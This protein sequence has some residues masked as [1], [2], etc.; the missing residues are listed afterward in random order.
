MEEVRLGL[1]LATETVA[2]FG[3]DYDEIAALNF[4]PQRASRKVLEAA[5]AGDKYWGK[6]DHYEVAARGIAET[7]R[8]LIHQFR[9]SEKILLPAIQVLRGSIDE[10]AARVE[11]LGRSTQ[12]ALGDHVAAL[13]AAGTVAEVM[14]YLHARIADWDVSVWHPG[15][16]EQAALERRLRVRTIGREP[17]PGDRALSADEALAGQRMLVVLGGP[18]SGKTWLARRYA[19]E[20]AHAA[21]LSLEDGADVDQVELPLFTTWDQWTKT[22]GGPRQALVAASFASGLGH[23]DPDPATPSTASSGPSLSRAGRCC[24]SS[25]PSTKQ[26]TSP[27]KPAGCMS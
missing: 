10:Y 13:V 20:A 6:E 17:S 21:L 1:A 22:P 2:R 19:R 16:Q 7:Y 23:S 5:N 11:S 8:V 4:D 14:A 18:G 15:Q 27:A 25:T 3:L 9:D 26:P 12:T 24:W